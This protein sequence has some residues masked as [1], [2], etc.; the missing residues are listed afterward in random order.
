MQF[1]P[2]QLH[3]FVTVVEMGQITRA[4]KHLHI[5]QPALSQAIA[6]LEAQLGV[7]LLDRH[8]RGVT[9][10]PAGEA[11]LVKARAV[12]N[13]EA[14]AAATAQSLARI[15]DGAIELGFLGTP[16]MVAAPGV[17]SAFARDHPDVAVSF[18][19]L[20]F[21]TSTTVAWLANVDLALCFSPAA[22]ADV[23]TLTLWR[24]PRSVLVSRSHPLA[25]RDELDVCEVLD[26]PF[27]GHAPSVDP[28]W[29]G[30]WTLD[31]HRGGPPKRVTDDRPE[32]SLEL[33][34][35]LS[36]G[37]AIRAFAATTAMTI[38]RLL[39]DLVA[40]P[41]RD[42]APAQCTLAWREDDR[43]PLVESFVETA[44]RPWAGERERA[45]RST[46]ARARCSKRLAGRRDGD[47][48]P[49]LRARARVQ[50][51]RRRLGLR[52]GAHRH[53]GRG[54]RVERIERLLLQQRL[55]EALE[56]VAVLVQQW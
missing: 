33:I 54:V 2:G 16:P 51:D 3:Y 43:S 49:C 12:L 28:A 22:H 53:A 36:S 56:L 18:R 24:E 37:R 29:A 32:N 23:A 50:R 7:R 6:Q 30:F 31:D 34:A 38:S 4:A 1:R 45:C 44:R 26:E 42:A 15:T 40:I 14:D 20:Q 27:Y 8:A 5:A 9:A 35:T 10:T 25:C 55:S 39:D 11:F 46:A 41:L 19:E 48:P 13:A 52:V 17:L 47:A 21:P